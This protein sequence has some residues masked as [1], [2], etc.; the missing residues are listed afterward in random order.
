MGPQSARVRTR[1]MQRPRMPRLARL[2]PPVVASASLLACG[3]GPSASR[4]DASP[5]GPE[6]LTV[7]LVRQ[8]DTASVA[9]TPPTRIA[10]FVA[11]YNRSTR[12]VR[13]TMR[14]PAGGL[15]LRVLGADGTVATSSPTVCRPEIHDGRVVTFAPG[16]SVW[17]PVSFGLAIPGTYR[18]RAVYE[19]VE[20]AARPAELS[21]TVL[22]P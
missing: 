17:F 2:L 14:C 12:T 15:A 19:A 13:A 7:A 6:S 5:V 1:A 11:A 21:V 16:D 20:G 4:P 9:I 22:A 3:D 18:L 10:V 8:P